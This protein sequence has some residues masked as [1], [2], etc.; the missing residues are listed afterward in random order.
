ML[1]RF[2]KKARTKPI[3]GRQTERND[4][5]QAAY[6]LWF[7]PTWAL[8]SVYVWLINFIFK[9]LFRWFLAIPLRFTQSDLKTG[10]MSRHFCFVNM[11][12]SN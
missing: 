1:I 11:I 8:Q 6:A 2:A 10:K 5:K 3:A 4:M 7:P 9:G 12:F